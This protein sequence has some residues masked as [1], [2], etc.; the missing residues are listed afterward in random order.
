MSTIGSVLLGEYPGPTVDTYGGPLLFVDRN[1]EEGIERYLEDVAAAYISIR[2][3]MDSR[4]HRAAL[5]D[6]LDHANGSR[7]GYVFMGVV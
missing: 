3:M 2:A 4:D 6:G 5:L 7:D 1:E